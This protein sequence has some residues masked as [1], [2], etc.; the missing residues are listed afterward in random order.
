MYWSLHSGLKVLMDSGCLDSDKNNLNSTL[1][2]GAYHFMKEALT[3][4]I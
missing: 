1:S 4:I 2:Y 3:M